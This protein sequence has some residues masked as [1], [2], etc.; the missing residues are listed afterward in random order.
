MKLFLCG[1]GSGKQINLAYQKF[2]KVIS[3]DKPIL[4]IPLA[5][6]ES[7][8]KS[9]FEWFKK[10]ISSIGL[11]NFEMI[12]SSKELSETNLNNYSALFIGG[13]NTYKLLCELKINNNDIKIQEYLKNQGVIFGASAGAIIFGND[14][15]S[16]L[17]EDENLVNLK[18]YK[19]FN[20]LNNYSILCHLNKKN[21]QK[22]KNYLNQ[23]SQK[24]NTIYLP[25]D[26]VI[27]ITDKKVKLLGNKKYM[28]FKKGKNYLHNFANFKKDI[29][30]K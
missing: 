6:D 28:I 13:G 2:K 8:Y 30:V 15:N 7:K 3:A 14:I 27:F 21:F 22:N 19:G 10:E 20:Y 11:S 23:Y 12:R 17:L 4:Y 24:N 16:C 18:N 5:M 26:N 9:C 29:N 1:G 25:E